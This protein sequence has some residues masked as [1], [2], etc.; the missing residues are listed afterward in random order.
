MATKKKSRVSESGAFIQQLAAF[1]NHI[2]R[3]DA[4]ERGTIKG[5]LRTHVRRAVGAWRESG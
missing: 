1:G 2:V 3:A 5:N 4:V